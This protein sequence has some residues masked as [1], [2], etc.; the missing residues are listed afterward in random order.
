MSGEIVDLL[1]DLL[2]VNTII[3]VEVLQITENSSKIARKS[4]IIPPQ[5]IESHGKI[6]EKLIG[7]LEKHFQ[8]NNF[9]DLSD[10]ALKH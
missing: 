3:A 4:D 5:C 7:L 2:Y 6:R 9:K 10:H 1:K 8:T